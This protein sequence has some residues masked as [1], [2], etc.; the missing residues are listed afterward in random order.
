[1]KIKK[2]WSSIAGLLLL[3]PALTYAQKQTYF[4]SYPALSPDGQTIVFSYDGDIWKVPVKGGL[5]S[6]ITAMQGEEINPKI[7]PDGKW[8]A[9]SSNQYGN[10]DVYIMPMSGG[11]IKQLTFNDAADEVD[12]WSWDSKTIYFTSSR[13]NNYSSYKVNINGGT[14]VRLFDNYFNTTH[15]IAEAPDGNLFFNDTWESRNFTNRKRYKGAYNPDIQS[16]NPKTKTYKRYTD[17]IG[18]DFWTTIDQKGNIYFVSDEANDEYNLYTFINGKKTALTKFDTSIKRPFVAANGNTVVFEKDYQLYVYDVAN[19]KAEKV[20]ISTFRNQTLAK[21]QEYEVRANI[22][23]FDVSP[24]GKKMA[25][26]SRGELFVSDVDGKFIR[27]ISNSGERALELKWLADNKTILFNQT[28]EGYQNWFTITGDGKSAPKQLTTD[29]ANNH[30]ISFNKART[31]AVYLSGRNE[32]R[33]MDLKTFQSKTVVR[34]EFWAI[35]NSSPSFSPNDQ[36]LLFTAYRNFEQDIFVHDIKANKTINLTN[37]GVTE[38]GPIWSPDGRYIYFTSSRTK[39]SYPLG[40]EDA[41]VYRMALDYYD[42]P[43]RSDKF[44][45]LF[46]ENA[47][48]APKETTPAKEDKKPTDTAKKKAEEKPAT[49]LITINTQRILD[50]IELVSPAF[51]TQYLTDV[52]AKGDKTYVFYSSSHEGFPMSTYR[53]VIEPF[54]NNKT[55]K[56]TE[57]GF[58]IAEVAGKYFVIARGAISK[59]NIDANKLDK[60]DHTYK[61]TKNLNAE[62]NQMFYE[63]WVGLDENFYDENFHGVDWEKMKKRYAAYLP[64]LNNRTDLR[65]LLNDML[66][67]L[68][69]S[70]MG[71]NSFGT[72]E[73]KSL[74]FVTNETGIIFNNENPYQVERIVAKSNAALLKD[75]IAKG[76]VLTHVNGVKVDAATDRDYYFTK[77]SLDKEM[78]LTFLRNGKS[79]DVNIHPQSSGAL[80]SNLYDEWIANNRKNVEEWGKNRIAYSYMKNMSKGELETFLL[81]MVEQENNKDAVILDLRYNTGGNVHDEVLRFLSQRPYLKWKYRGGA[82]SPQSNFAPAAKP[83]VLL[84]NE[85]SLSDAEMTAAGFKQ[86]KLGK[87]IGTETY[88]W[89]IFTSAKGLVDGSSYRLPSWGCYTMDGKNLEKEGVSPDIY[90]KNTFE[91]RLAGR[92]PQLERAIAEIMKDLK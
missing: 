3:L 75:K 14:A 49:K 4:A 65:I 23:N 77:P 54:E 88:R 10:F 86:L 44:D 38:A 2:I 8:L 46:K 30:D 83:I 61:F 51:G 57:G 70:H 21:E 19:K 40:M 73:R 11:D 42:T 20:D 34:D 64:Y 76:D 71:F 29:K 68:N 18:K 16:Y 27:K 55:E 25:F 5:A 43:Y 1:M 45:E 41:H 7:S 66:G 15:N 47:P 56:V 72:E 52:L 62:F 63:T 22:S 80:K 82:I 31:Q 13:Y 89:I 6:R 92:D 50:R 69:S 28:T 17:Y 12:N 53:T 59:Y 74:N 84:I 67:E 26:I 24:D 85:Q 33:I 39:P 48:V 32:L 37:T 60:I 78:S 87:I 79:V 90:V 81:D 36:Y 35:Q 58:G 91:D 9:F